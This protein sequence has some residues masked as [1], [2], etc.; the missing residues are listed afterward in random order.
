MSVNNK[1]IVK[2]S[3]RRLPQAARKDPGV[4]RGRRGMDYGRRQDRT[5]QGRHSPMDGIYGT[6]GAPPVDGP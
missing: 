5:R 6:H 3:T 4:L 2:R 1:A